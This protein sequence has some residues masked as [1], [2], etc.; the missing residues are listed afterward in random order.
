[1]AIPMFERHTGEVMLK[2]ISEFFDALCPQRRAK[3]VGVSDGASSMIE[4]VKGVTRLEREAQYKLYRIWCGIHQL[5]LVMNHVYGDL[6]NGKFNQIM[7]QLT[8]YLRHQYNL[9]NDMQTTCPKATETRWT[10]MGITS[11]WLLE[12]RVPI[13]E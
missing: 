13:L 1:M 4:P 2:L 10:M 9:I 3:L 11:Q 6:E 5:D 12:S 7:H 8:G